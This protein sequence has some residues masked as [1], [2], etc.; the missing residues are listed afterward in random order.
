M[1][2]VSNRGVIFSS[3]S[4]AGALALLN[5][6]LTFVNIWP[7]LFVKWMGGLSVELAV[8]VLLMVLL[9]PW[10]ETTSR[11]LKWLAAA[12]VVLVVARYADVTSRSLYGRDV[13]LYWDLRLMP[14]VSA[15]FAVVAKPWLLALVIGGVV[16]IP[17]LLYLPL[18]WAL[19]RLAIASSQPVSR[20]ALGAI[21]ALMLLVWGVQTVDARVPMLRRVR[22]EA[23][24]TAT[25]AGQVAQTVYE[26]TGTGLKSLPPPVRLE[27][28]FANVNGADVALIFLEAYG[29]TSWDRPE[30]AAPLQASRAQFVKDV[31][32]A[33]REIVS[34]FVESTTFGG[35]SWLSHL[36]LLSGTEV[37][38]QNTTVRL[39]AQDRDTLVKAFNRHGYRTVAIMPGLQRGWPE[40]AF[41]GFDQIYGAAELDYGERPPFGWWSVTD[42]YALAVV[43]RREIA[44]AGR[45]P[46]FMFFPTISSHAPFTP[47]PPYQPDWSRVMLSM[48]YDPADLD[49]AW[50]DE[51]D[52][53]NLSP[54]YVKAL[55]YSYA[56]F[57]GYLKLRADR[58][59][60]MILIGD[61]QPASLVSGEGASWDVP[62]H[63]IS[64][65]PE[66]MRRLEGLGFQKGLTPHH[67]RIAQMN[68]LL[69]MLLDA[70]NS[71]DQRPK[72]KD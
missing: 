30:L 48:P 24:V 66:L 51:A 26:A 20:H 35:E 28:D 34:A 64:N 36:T 44:P 69:Y 6:S 15:M 70:F 67:P 40:G 29:A 31:H 47:A 18:R 5:A 58:N 45:K 12:W 61:H 25:L 37:R 14:D 54:S 72:T 63:V 59:M 23:P 57:G 50:A 62:I 16:L 8:C 43:D 13:N 22:F 10:F 60:V 38:D 32:D 3:F 53:T 11:T 4:L 49:R 56:T 21:A 52:W 65:K 17:L 9:R 27:S 2:R 41:Y 46:V 7:T 39:M 33:G 19:V 1:G 55:E 42:Q 68:T 71:K